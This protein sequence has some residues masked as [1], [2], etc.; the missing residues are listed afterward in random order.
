MR[1]ENGNNLNSYR[2]ST[3]AIFRHRFKKK[4][5]SLAMSAGYNNSLS[6]GTENL[7]SLNKFFQATTFTDQIR[8]LNTNEN[9]TQQIKSSLLFTEPLSKKWYWE[10]F[11]NLNSTQNEVRRQVNDPEKNNERVDKLSVFYDNKVLYNRLGSSFRY[12]HEGVN[13]TAGL[14]VQQLDLSGSYSIDRNLPLLTTPVK[15]SFPNLTPNVTANFELPNNKYL[16]FS[17]DY[18]VKEPQLNDLQPVPNVNNPAFRVVNRS[19]VALW[20][21]N[22][23]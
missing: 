12:A 8:Q 10:T 23:S 22:R 6:D 9:A 4:G 7:F 18:D 5:R 3:A 16:R 20:H 17:Y 14:A 19:I 1:L 15:R 2:L 11:Y 21:H 13:I